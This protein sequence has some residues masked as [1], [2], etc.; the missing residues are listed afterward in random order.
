MKTNPHSTTRSL[1]L[2]A[3]FLALAFN[4]TKN[5]P[6]KML[7]EYLEKV[8]V[9]FGANL[10]AGT[11]WDMTSYMMKDVPTS[12]EGIIDSALLILHDWSHFIALQP[13]EIDSERGVIMEELRT[14]DNASW[15]STMKMLQALGKG[16]KY[17]HRNLIGYLDGLKGFQHKELEDFY[18]TWYR[19][20]YQAVV[21]VGDIDVDAVENKLK[22]L[23]SDIPAPAAD[24][25]Q[26]EVITVPDNE[27]P[28]VSIYTDPEMQGT[29]VQLFIKR[30][31][32]PE[33]LANTVLAEANNVIE[34]YMTTMENARL[35]EIAMQPDAPFLGAGM[36]TGDV[37]GIIP[38][39]DATVFVAMTED[40]KL[41]RS[42]ERRVGKECRSRW[43][44][45]H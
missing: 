1:V 18:N 4:G 19:P 21:I 14:R 32:L 40:G 42:E 17:E 11:S 34:A 9:K 8:G 13:E 7:T 38:T 10:N 26:K 2:A 44:P 15:R 22:T 12:R 28:I 25:A 37:I 30:P 24:A 29:K 33:Q 31:A 27:E 23:M 5:L 3:L 39:L 20:D 36:G 41:A 45:Y 6:G 35:Q 43:S 16:T